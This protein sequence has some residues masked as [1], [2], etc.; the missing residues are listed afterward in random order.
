MKTVTGYMR[1]KNEKL[2][3]D[4]PMVYCKETGYWVPSAS[5]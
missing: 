2:F 4:G 5:K 1:R 3:L